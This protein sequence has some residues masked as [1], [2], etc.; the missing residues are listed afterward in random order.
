MATSLFHRVRLYSAAE[1]TG[2]EVV[3]SPSL[4]EIVRTV[5][6]SRRYVGPLK[7][8]AFGF[9]AIVGVSFVLA[10]LT[11]GQMNFALFGLLSMVAVVIGL[12]DPLRTALP[13]FG[14]RWLWARVIAWCALAVAAAVTVAL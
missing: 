12:V 10:G 5:P 1:M 3:A 4:R 11:A 2:D 13:G 7:I 8:S 14:S 6:A 9:V